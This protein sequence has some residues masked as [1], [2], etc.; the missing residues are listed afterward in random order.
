M[1]HCRTCGQQMAEEI[2]TC[3]SCGNETVDKLTHIDGYLIKKILHEGHATILCRAEHAQTRRPALIRIFKAHSGIN[4]EIANRLSRELEKLKQLPQDNFVRHLEFCRSSEGLWYRVSEWNKVL[5]WGS[6]L[7]SGKLQNLGTAFDLFIKITLILDKLHKIGHTIPHL[8]LDDIIVI[9]DKNN[10]LD[11]KIDYKLSRFLNPMMDRPGPMLKKLLACHPDILGNR[12]VDRRTDIWSLGKIFV[13][14]L[15]GDHETVD[16]RKKID[17]MAL[18]D[19]IRV[20]LRI[21][22]A[23][24][25]D[26]RPRSMSQVAKTLARATEADFEEARRSHQA[27]IFIAS[28]AM[29]RMK[30][31]M[32]L[33]T[34]LMVVILAAG[35]IFWLK[36]PLTGQSDEEILENYANKY[37]GSVAFLMA[38]YQLI[39]EKDVVYENRV[40]GTAFLVDQE[41]YLLTN[42]HVACP[43]LEDNRLHLLI[44]G[45]K[46]L[47]R[48]PRLDYRLFLWFEGEKAF[49][50]LPEQ[51]AILSLDDSYYL[52]TA[53]RTGGDPKLE[54]AGVARLPVK[55]RQLVKSPLKN[56]FA[57]LKIDSVPK[58]LTVMPMNEN[59]DTKK[60]GRLAPVITLGFPLGSQTQETTI[61]TSVT[62]GHIR[63]TFKNLL[64]VDTSI[65]HGNS[66]G[67]LIDTSG[68]V[69]GIASRVAMS[70]T[71]GPIP[72]AT[73]LPDIGLVLPISKA[74]VFIRELKAGETKWRGG[75]DLFAEA[76]LENITQLAEEGKWHKAAEMAD[77]ELENSNDMRLIIAAGMMHFII[78]DLP[79]A[80][81][82][83]Q[84]ALSMNPENILASYM[85]FVIDWLDDRPKFNVQKQQLLALDWRSS[86]E[87]FGY[88]TRVL[89]ESIDQKSAQSGGW[90]NSNE[91]SWILYTI[92]L[93]HEKQGDLNTA[94]ALLIKAAIGAGWQDWLSHL[95]FARL[96]GIWDQLSLKTVSDAERKAL[97]EKRYAFSKKIKEERI[98]GKKQFINLAPQLAMLEHDLSDPETKLETLNKLLEHMPD[99][100]QV[101]AGIAFY[102]AMMGNWEQSLKFCRKFSMFNGREN[103]D[104]LS[105][106][107]LEPQLLL[108]L[109]RNGDAEK[110]FQTYIETTKDPWHR[111]IAR[112]LTGKLS[113]KSLKSKAEAGPE[114]LV[115]AHMALGFLA[116]SKNNTETAMKHY[117]EA[118]GSYM[119]DWTEYEFSLE[120][121]KRLKGGMKNN[122][123]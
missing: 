122:T 111:S 49:K 99:N 113:E 118:L 72:F 107:L 36:F 19:E 6:L 88:L 42:R 87:F 3:P 73:H 82:L 43:W 4:E 119:D 50:R 120:R 76:K 12:P 89:E 74:A 117:K 33:I 24:D 55:T 11:V 85:L 25:P 62:R 37:A 17:S 56:D 106:G 54:I 81:R 90:Y 93:I 39:D 20:L 70:W 115:T 46:V 13:E 9:K 1:K 66:G 23:D 79:A 105:I 91:K 98:V 63:R 30:T 44:N 22:L 26:L 10:D 59:L 2:I 52:E 14:I 53:Y 27:S 58:G 68:K 48:S 123:G 84:Q 92:A 65:H 67:P 80:A 57:V 121:I 7:T 31:R 41:G 83:F 51:E 5:S 101:V 64:Q 61:N 97:E 112:C 108:M 34:A 35:F 60:I 77:L 104:R 95:A 94:E 28:G 69:I 16:F 18:P 38:E 96:E 40:E 15:S 8:I 110:S 114:Y 78:N 21:M 103:A 102:H 100:G 116:E 75:M 71:Q 45:L 109:G 47:E 86:L 29:G 32:R